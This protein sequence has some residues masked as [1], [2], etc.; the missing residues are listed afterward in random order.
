MRAVEQTTDAAAST[1]TAAHLE[2]HR[3]TAPSPRRK[4][5]VSKAPN[6]KLRLLPV[7]AIAAARKRAFA[8]VRRTPT[9]D[10]PL[11]FFHLPKTGGSSLRHSPTFLT[12]SLVPGS[13][14]FPSR[15]RSASWRMTS[16]ATGRPR[17]RR[18]RT[19]QARAAAQDAG[20]DRRLGW[21]RRAPAVG[22][23]LARKAA[24]RR[25]RRR[26]LRHRA[27][28]PRARW[29]HYLHF[30]RRSRGGTA[31]CRS[32]RGTRALHNSTSRLAASS[33]HSR[34]GFS[35]PLAGVGRRAGRAP[36]VQ[37]VFPDTPGGE[38]AAWLAGPS[39]AQ[40]CPRP[41]AA[42]GARRGGPRARRR[43][44]APAG[45]RRSG[46]RAP[47]ATRCGATTA[48]TR[49]APAAGERTARWIA[50]LMYAINSET[51]VQLDFKFKNDVVEV[52]SPEKTSNFLTNLNKRGYYESIHSGL[53]RRFRRDKNFNPGVAATPRDCVGAEVNLLY[54][55]PVFYGAYLAPGFIHLDK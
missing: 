55:T 35:G 11:L 30:H 51:Q 5:S 4:G 8:G 15:R 52:E 49:S 3:W 48:W 40:V 34:T 45:A 21:V 42:T 38:A 33:S 18:S 32:S 1:H 9:R 50:E 23:G 27:A 47:S 28:S 41:H 20:G 6:M 24:G 22:L 17:D 2:A 26:G 54:F 12:V 10:R 29:R 16:G 36:Q 25:A 31:R 19:P 37:A 39:G 7:V 53:A 44:S 46:A 13:G 43:S 14:A